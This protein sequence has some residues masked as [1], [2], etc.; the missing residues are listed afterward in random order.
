MPLDGTG[1]SLVAATSGQ[2]PV[3]FGEDGMRE[4][5]IMDRALL[6][7]EQ[8][9]EGPAVITEPTATTLVLPGQQVHVDRLGFLHI[10]EI[11]SADRV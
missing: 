1:R 7:L 9:I 6:P 8:D 2:R 4:T 11:W 10:R 5:P 3:H